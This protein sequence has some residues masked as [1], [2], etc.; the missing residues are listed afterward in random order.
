MFS[1]CIFPILLWIDYLCHLFSF[2]SWNLLSYISTATST[3]LSMLYAG[4]ITFI[5]IQYLYLQLKYVSWRQHRVGLWFLIY[6]TTF[7]F[8]IGE[9][10][11]FTFRVIIDTWGSSIAILPIVTVILHW[12]F[13]LVFLPGENFTA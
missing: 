11:P 6:L 3:F 10:I 7:C 5:S 13:P 4:S 8:L 12:F 1:C 2:Y 9:F